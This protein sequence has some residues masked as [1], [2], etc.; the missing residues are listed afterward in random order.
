MKDFEGKLVKINLNS[1]AGWVG[2]TGEYIKLENDFLVI[3]D[4]ITHKIH[5]LSMYCVKSV[6]IIN[7]ISMVD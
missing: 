1:N 4:K 2:I 5:Y 6:E 3:R 7:K